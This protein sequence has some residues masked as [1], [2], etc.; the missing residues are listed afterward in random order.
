MQVALRVEMSL[1]GEG[2][3]RKREEEEDGVS[4]GEWVKVKPSPL[5]Y[6]QYRHINHSRSKHNVTIASP[7]GG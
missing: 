4:I 5:P 3:G 1:G 7:H 2:N 6:L